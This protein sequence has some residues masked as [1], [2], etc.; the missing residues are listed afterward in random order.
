MIF[1]DNIG[2]GDSANPPE[3]AHGKADRQQG[4]GVDVRRQTQR[5]LSFFLELQV[6][7]HQCRAEAEG[8]WREQHVL[9]PRDDF[10]GLRD[11]ADKNGTQA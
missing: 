5:R 8:R 6:Q 3:P 9:A 2:K 7:R 4:I 11:R 1:V 10:L